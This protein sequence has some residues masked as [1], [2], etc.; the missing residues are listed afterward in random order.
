M[1][2]I[3]SYNDSLPFYPTD[4]KT[5]HYPMSAGTISYTKRYFE[6]NNNITFVL[7][8]H[9]PQLMF[10]G[11]IAINHQDRYIYQREDSVRDS[12]VRYGF[13]M[14]NN[15]LQLTPDHI[16]A[17]KKY[18]YLFEEL[19]FLEYPLMLYDECSEDDIFLPIYFRCQYE[20]KKS[21]QLLVMPYANMDFPNNMNTFF[22][23]TAINLELLHKRQIFFQDFKLQNTVYYHKSSYFIDIDH[24]CRFK[25]CNDMLNK[26]MDFFGGTYY[27]P[28]VELYRQGQAITIEPDKV[29]VWAFGIELLEYYKN[30]YKWN[31][32]NPY[33][34]NQS[35][36]SWQQSTKTYLQEKFNQLFTLN[37]KFCRFQTIQIKLYL[38][39]LILNCLSNQESRFNISKVNQHHFWKKANSTKKVS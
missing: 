18:N 10:K 36:V 3:L 17:V 23:M 34:N 30:K 27:P 19:N 31:I 24:L 1:H 5:F 33:C 26:N 8:N 38:L 39:D 28:E 2:K 16:V 13:L 32:S 29:D 11:L 7:T 20:G 25:D 35:I 6:I 4:Y 37:K 9:H 21:S 15:K 12:V 22:Q 14:V